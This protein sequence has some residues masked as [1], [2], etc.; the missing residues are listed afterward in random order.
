MIK[1]VLVV[2]MV[3]GS[4]VAANRD[5]QFARFDVPNR[6]MELHNF[7]TETVNLDGWRFC[8]HSGNQIRRYSSAGGFDGLSIDAGESL[9]IYL[10][11]NAPDDANAF[12]ASDIGG[13][14]ANMTAGPYGISFYFP[15][16]GGSVTFGNGNLIADHIQ[17]SI[18][19][20]DDPTAD[21]RS[22]EAV[23][24]GVWTG[25]EDWV[26][27]ATDT[28]WVVLTD[29]SGA[30]M[31][32]PADYQSLS[33]LADFNNDNGVDFF[34]IQEFLVLF[35]SGAPKADTN[36]DGVHDFFDVSRMLSLFS[37]GCP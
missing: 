11:N 24:G 9:F 4:A 25:E 2:G 28:Q 33:C 10:N 29:L 3:A 21:E 5:V 1:Q 13:Q 32:G 22:D 23:A 19:G 26:S 30:Q 27:V 12:D 20:V 6:I 37:A 35:S 34:D 7:G 8:S 36:L 18:G 16:A 17:W 31:H 14:F 15:S